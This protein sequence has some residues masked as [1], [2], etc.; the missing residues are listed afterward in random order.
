VPNIS[1]FNHETIQALHNRFAPHSA[2]EPCAW[3]ITRPY[4]KIKISEKNKLS[5]VNLNI[6]NIYLLVYLENK[7]FEAVLN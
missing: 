4:R 6:V 2:K 7:L 5:N 1:A 3:F